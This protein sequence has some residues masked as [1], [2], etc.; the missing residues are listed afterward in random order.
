MRPLPLLL[1]AWLAL[2]APA[3]ADPAREAIEAANRGFIAAFLRGDAAALASF[4]TE[5]AQVIAPGSPVAAGRP[6]IAAFWQG[7]I[8]SGVKDVAL[9]THAVESDG[10]LAAETGTVRQIAADGSASSGRYVVVWRRVGGE[11]KL[12]RDIWN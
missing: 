2:P 7:V 11:W 12:H 5:S 6:A 8:Q 1:L 9:Q 10:D 3:G 4:Y